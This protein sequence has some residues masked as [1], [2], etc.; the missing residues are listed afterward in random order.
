M[1]Q[2]VFLT[3]EQ[4]INKLQNEK[5]L[6]IND[7]EYA[8]AILKKISYYSLI[9]GYKQ[10][11]KAP[12]TKKYIYGVTFEEIWVVAHLQ[13]NHPLICLQAH[14]QLAH[15]ARLGAQIQARCVDVHYLCAL[16]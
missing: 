6:I 15:H 10:L 7:S 13:H 11:F 9:S 14:Q 16:R 3:Y 8:T 5:Y 1:N 4:Q 2:K 12:A